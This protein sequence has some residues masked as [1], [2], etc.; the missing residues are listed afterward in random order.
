[1][2]RLAMELQLY[3][4]IVYVGAVVGIPFDAAGR[5]VSIP[6]RVVGG[7]LS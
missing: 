4:L 5:G 6:L 1:M 2:A 7:C 3:N